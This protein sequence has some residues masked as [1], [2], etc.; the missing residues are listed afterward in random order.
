M[1]A[2]EQGDEAAL[3]EIFAPD[4]RQREF[5]NRLLAR[6][7]ERGLPEM[8]DGFRRGKQVVAHQR[9]VVTSALVDGERVAVEVRWTAE[10]MVPLGQLAAGD[11]IAAHCGMFFRIENGRIAQQHNFDCFEPF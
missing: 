5:P 3:L 2:I 7:A 9:Y 1:H 10:L 6:G 8:L 4:V 11:T